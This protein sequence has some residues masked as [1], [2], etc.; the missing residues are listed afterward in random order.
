MNGKS[1]TCNWDVV[2]SYRVGKLNAV[3]RNMWNRGHYS[4]AE[5]DD[6]MDVSKKKRTKYRL[7][8]N[9]PTLQFV[10]DGAAAL[11]T[12]GI[13]GDAYSYGA[14]QTFDEKMPVTATFYR[15]QYTLQVE[16][17]IA[18]IPAEIVESG[19][20]EKFKEAAKVDHHCVFADQ[21]YKKGH[22]I[23]FHFQA[24]P[25]ESW[26]IVS[27]DAKGNINPKIDATLAA[28]AA[29]LQRWFLRT[30]KL[31]D[32]TIAKIVN[33]KSVDDPDSVL[34]PL[35][36]VLSAQGQGDSAS[37]SI[38]MQTKGSTYGPGDRKPRFSVAASPIP[39][40]HDA[41]IILRYE[42][43]R[44][45]FF[46]K[47]LSAS[48]KTKDSPVPV[49]DFHTEGEPG[50]DFGVSIDRTFIKNGQNFDMVNQFL[51][52]Y[53]KGDTWHLRDHPIKLRIR[54]AKASWTLSRSSILEWVDINHT[55]IGEPVLSSTNG[56]TIVEYSVDKETSIV[57][58]ESDISTIGFAFTK[59]DLK[60]VPRAGDEPPKPLHMRILGALAG[61]QWSNEVPEVYKDLHATFEDA[62]V[63]A[64]SINFFATKN[65]FAG[66]EDI[67]SV[68]GA[69]GIK[70][71]HDV[72]L[73]GRVVEPPIAT[74][75]DTMDP[76]SVAG[77]LA[78][79][80]A[81]A[82]GAFKLVSLINTIKQGGKQRLRL[83][84][85]LN[86]LW[87]VIKL[88]EGHFD[89]EEQ[90]LNEHWLDTIQLLDEDGG[91]FD[92]ISTVFESL[93][94]R[95]Q[96][97]MGH[98]KVMQ[99]LRWPYD[100]P[101]VEQLTA[102]L[103]RLKN[104]VS[105]AYNSTSAAAVREIQSDTKYIKQSVTKDEVKA[106]IDWISNLN[107]LKQQAGFV[108]QAREGTGKWF[109]DRTEFQSWA[110]SHEAMLWC[111]GIVGAGKTFLASIAM[112]YLKNTR[113]DQNVAV[114]ILF[115]GYN[116][117]RSQSVDKLVAALIKELLQIRPEVS[118]E[119]KKL[120]EESSRIDVLP[121]LAK[122]LPILRA[123][124]AKF[125][126]CFIVIDGLDEMLDEAQRRN[127]LE[128]LTHSKVNIMITSRPLDSIR[129]LFSF[130]ADITCDGCEEENFR[131]MYHCK[132]CLGYGFDLCDGCHGKGLTCPEGGHYFVKTFCTSTIE[133]QATPTDI[134]NYVEWRIDH[135]SKLFD[136]VNKKK[137][138]RE[139]ILMTIVQ[140]ANGMFLLAKLHMDSL[141][142]KRTP[143]AV[144]IAL[145]NLPTEIG[146]TYDRAM[147]RIEA[148]N[149]DDRKIVMNFLLWI[150][151][152]E[153][154][155][156]VSEIE[157]ASAI[158][159]GASDVDHDNILSASELTSMCAG[160]VIVDASDI[161]RLV[162]FSARNYFEQH[163][164]K[165]FSNGHT[166]L[167][168]KC[169][170]YLSYKVFAAGA[171]S[172]QD[173]RRDFYSKIEQYPLID[174]SCSYW[175]FH[176]RQ[177]EPSEELTD[178]IVDFMTSTN[179]L[180]FA[181]QAMWYSDSPDLTDWDV[182]SGAHGLHVAAFFGLIQVVTR[183][184]KGQHSVDCRDSFGT[185]PLMYAAAAGH[186]NVVQVLLREGA[187]PSFA[188]QRS[189]T[190]LHRA[191]EGNY[192][193]VVRYL[194]NAPNVG[195]N[196]ISTVRA[197][198]T[199]L[200]LAAFYQ[201]ADMVP[202]ILQTPELDVNLD[203]GH[204]QATLTALSLA[205]CYENAQIVRQILGHPAIDVNKRDGWCTPLTN[206][207]RNGC[208]SVVEV[209]LDHGADP[210]IQEGPQYL[211]GTPLN[212]AID[213]GFAPVVKL[214][215]ERGANP[216]V[217]DIYNRTIIH[218]AA[219]NGRNE[220]LR[221]LFEK[222]TGVD[223]NAQGTNGRT[224]LHDAAYFNYCETIKILFEHGARTDIRDGADRSPLGV[225][226][227]MNNLEALE[228]LRK[229]RKQEITRDALG[230]N[231]G[232]LKHTQS[233]IDSSQT[234]FLT[235]VKLGMKD[236]VNSYIESSKT[237]PSV[238]INLIDLDRHSALHIAVKNEH[239]DVL[240]TLLAAPTIDVNIVDRLGRSALHW[241][242]IHA[243][244]DA[245][246]LLL[247]AGAD[248]TLKD[249]FDDTALDIALRA[250]RASTVG[251]WILE[252]GAMPREQDVQRALQVAVQW[253]SP[254]L[255][256][257]VVREG[258]ADP[259]RK[260]G[261]GMT[262][263]RR[264]EE[265]ENL[266]VVE[267]ILGLCEERRRGREREKGKGKDK[268]EGEEEKTVVTK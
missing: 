225:A 70:T 84:T 80:E 128:I 189:T 109:L 260:D 230:D 229:L 100:K 262:L 131:F 251:Y 127:L 172:G 203:A 9:S 25:A 250:N 261:R 72:L 75:K 4:Q 259:E 45:S 79:I 263:V 164:E 92:Q 81:L 188:C 114:L 50:F 208:L 168:R 99:T 184:I 152:S 202:M 163:R 98:R 199:P 132:Q 159:V 91:I 64:M 190:A 69:D 27:T 181:V 264:A 35:S 201:R 213:E 227:D 148:T 106:I 235:A 11:L 257:K 22:N 212:R 241:S 24:I 119:L 63:H 40:G 117:E 134:R 240:S 41:S 155:L 1:A 105:L 206:A 142:T 133:I 136:S 196:A 115:C 238:D 97:K 29:V 56:K 255:V 137:H 57:T 186:V 232:P 187:D 12:M 139:E 166:T 265:W 49:L 236:A 90:N 101:E 147:E 58:T 2:V 111:P 48:L 253:G 38:F 182:K 220:I 249:H 42:I 26:K 31:V 85:E 13:E 145:Q 205:A 32:Y 71:P 149:E 44:D 10:K 158:S 174:Y 59:K 176:G 144:H 254:E 243:V 62:S 112:E 110:S 153:R 258:G 73:L 52:Q 78:S 154:P 7:K 146:D 66:G 86:S 217:Q 207:A 267:V 118:E 28:A 197:G 83:F 191:I 103:E 161:V 96:P 15:G 140:Q 77:L 51:L 54:D 173:E 245:A 231:H 244:P 266:G 185:T 211:S 108:S 246:E 204:D 178:Q 177:A 93:T 268:E 17:P 209:L 224:A 219:V 104:T 43:L 120:F 228:L 89:P 6:V 167:A 169:V 68:S 150:A 21:D 151:F 88:L 30:V 76:A 143:K 242:A 82:E 126:Q 215:L 107:F 194:L 160:L 39:D 239:I 248:F 129:G 200:M 221:V 113:K 165:W 233:S 218:S 157:H 121:S 156:S 61:S 198:Y 216:K 252:H 16:V 60:I 210:E 20:V 18:T 175:G 55:E 171:C 3:L 125:D 223:I 34:Q 123:E 135:E 141:A 256:E 170:A 36:F 214:L 234:G 19:D 180:D 102:H 247:N 138:L 237:D 33:E 95:L 46:I 222:S 87:M 130:S 122:L 5:V 65:V 124:M 74:T 53:S 37:L 226:K 94:N 116:E 8:V 195:V 192:V 23:V 14:D 67:I 193:D 47:K 162:H 179:R 183:L